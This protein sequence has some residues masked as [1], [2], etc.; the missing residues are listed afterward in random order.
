M[1]LIRYL[2]WYRLHVSNRHM[3]SVNDVH[4]RVSVSSALHNRKRTSHL[5]RGAELVEFGFILLGLMMLLLG[6][7]EFARAYNIYQT[8]TRAAR[9]GAHAAVMP[10]SSADG[11]TY[12]LLDTSSY[13]VGTCQVPASTTSSPSTPTFDGPI[14]QALTASSLNPAEV[15][16]YEEC[17]GWINPTTTSDNQ[18]GLTIAFQYPVQLNIP[19]PFANKPWVTSFNVQT[20]VTMRLEDVTYKPNGDGT[21]S[22]SCP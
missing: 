13:S 19:I 8:I 22:E 6:I 21:Y 17:V 14:S 7:F 5:E 12:T 2:N 18:C 9:E 10:T 15:Q 4:S 16:Q 11:N 3:T 1:A 20:S